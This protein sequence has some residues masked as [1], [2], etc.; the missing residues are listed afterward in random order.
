MQ[1]NFVSELHIQLN[2]ES[3][4]SSDEP[5]SIWERFEGRKKFFNSIRLWANVGDICISLNAVW[6]EINTMA[7]EVLSLSIKLLTRVC[8]LWTVIA[9]QLAEEIVQLVFHI[10][11]FV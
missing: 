3:M 11:L 1:E 2:L 6:E 8:L 7:G 10:N 5:L 9:G 4:W